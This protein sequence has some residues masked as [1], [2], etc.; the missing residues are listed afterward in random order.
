MKTYHIISKSQAGLH[1]EQDSLYINEGPKRKKQNLH[2]VVQ[3]MTFNIGHISC[4]QPWGRK[5]NRRRCCSTA[6]LKP[7]PRLE[8][9]GETGTMQGGLL[10]PSPTLQ[11]L[12][13]LLVAEHQG[14]QMAEEPGKVVWQEQPPQ[15]KQGTA[16]KGVSGQTGK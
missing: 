5:D 2:H 4:Y 7:H 16:R 1:L 12:R 13:C 8:L 14:E 11:F 10:L 6:G 9:P 15:Y 3:Q